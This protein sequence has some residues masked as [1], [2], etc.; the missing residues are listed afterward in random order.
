MNLSAD[1]LTLR[2]GS[3]PPVLE[4]ITLTVEP[5][6]V[7]ALIGPNAGGKSTLLRSLARAHPPHSGRVSIGPDDL[8]RL[9]AREAARRIAYV[10]QDNPMPFAFTVSELIAL[11]ADAAPAVADATDRSRRISDAAALFD[12][13]P[14]ADR[15]LLTLSGGERQRAALARAFAQNTPCLLLDEPTLH[16][17]LRHQAALL[18]AVRKAAREKGQAVLLVL[19]DINQA[20]AVADTLLLLSG[21]RIAASGGAATVLSAS[22]LSEA[23]QTEV[24]LLPDPVTGTPH[25]ALPL[26]PDTEAAHSPSDLTSS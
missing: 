21:G 18:G 16:L 22:R 14:L 10:P 19:H 17:D 15:N 3:L 1:S 12:M 25:I 2:Y 8:Y 6:R 20:A 5:G 9:P 23:Y 11:G 4:N 13:E 26:T 7:T 24:R